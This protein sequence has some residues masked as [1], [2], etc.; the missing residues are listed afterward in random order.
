MAERASPQVRVSPVEFVTQ[1]RRSRIRRWPIIPVAI[2]TVFVFSAAF[3]PWISPHDPTEAS[4]RD[5]NTPPVWM[6]GGKATFLLGTDTLGRDVLSRI[7]HGARVSVMIAALAL[8]TSMIIGV[9]LGLVA[10]YYGRTID[11]VIIRFTDVNA[12]IPFLLLA[13]VVVTV[14]GQSFMTVV[15]VLAYSAWSG[16]TRLVRA[17]ALLLREA[18]YVGLAKVAGA[19]DF[20]IMFRHILPGTINTI[21]IVATLQVGGLILTESILS[22]LGA[23]I[24]PPTPAWGA[25]IAQGRDYL[26]S[27]WWIAFFP[28]MALFLL[29]LALNFMGDWLRD[30]FDPRLRQTL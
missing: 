11:E 15:W 25:M 28:G 3:A 5:R 1:R 29:V 26:A 13:L 7:I 6:E 18:D 19:S 2:L 8:T 24:P 27:A 14:V 23:G 20:R 12:A 17:E 10:G 16:F 21:I 22:F 4:L 30:N 9:T